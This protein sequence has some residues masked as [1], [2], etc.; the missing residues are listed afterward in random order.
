MGSLLDLLPD[1]QA[2]PI[3]LLRA[4]TL[5]YGVHWMTWLP[6]ALQQTLVRDFAVPVAPIN[7]AKALAAATVAVQ[8]GFWE[9]WEHFHF[10]TQALSN[11]IPDASNHKELTLSQMM[12]A[13]DIA[14]TIREE[15]RDLSPV[16]PFSEEVSKYVAAQALA[17]GVWYLP[18]PLE[19]AARYASGRRYHCKDCNNDSE[20][21]FG[22]GLCDT[23]TE[24]FCTERLGAWEPDPKLLAKGW[25]RNIA[26]YERNPTAK[27]KKRLEELSSHPGRT[28][29]ETQTDICTARIL[30]AMQFLGVRRTQFKEQT[31]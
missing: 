8:P 31:A 26:Y 11:N 22:D 24:R 27:V 1:E 5:R 21:L 25:G 4:I 19:F 28:L 6:S 20:D 17:A 13:V 2:H 18:E 12:V 16:P 3:A 9:E 29:Q 23:C 30:V 15:L 10:L 7:L 14:R